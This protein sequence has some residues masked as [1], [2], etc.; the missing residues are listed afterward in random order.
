MLPWCE[1]VKQV[2]EYGLYFTYIIQK[3]TAQKLGEEKDIILVFCKWEGVSGE[4]PWGSVLNLVLFNIFIGDLTM[5]TQRNLK[6]FAACK[7][8]KTKHKT[9]LLRR[10]PG[11]SATLV[12][13]TEVQKSSGWHAIKKKYHVLQKSSKGNNEKSCLYRCPLPSRLGLNTGKIEPAW[14][15]VKKVKFQ[16]RL[17]WYKVI[18]VLYLYSGVCSWNTAFRFRHCNWK[19]A[20]TWE[21]SENHLKNWKRF[22]SMICGVR[23][24]GTKFVQSRKERMKSKVSAFW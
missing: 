13:L 12:N 2:R 21:I 7:L 18:I 4:G 10:E 14:K 23:F 17:C 5:E 22:K 6:T 24:G 8:D 20:Q 9:K 16:P 19:F 1:L 3:I 15:L 11:F